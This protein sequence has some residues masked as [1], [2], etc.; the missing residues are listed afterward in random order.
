MANYINKK[1]IRGLLPPRPE[2]SN[3][4]T[5]G[6]VL[7]IA[8]S[9]NYIGAAHLSSLSALKMG[10][11]Y[12]SLACPKSIIPIIASTLHE[13]TFIPM[14]ETEDGTISVENK[15]SNLYEYNV[16][17]IG[18]GITTNDETRR[19]SF[20][21]INELNTTQKVIIDADGINMLANHK[22]EISL[23]NAIITPHPKELSRLLNVPVEEILNNREKYARITSQTYE[24]ITVL[25][26][27][28]SI[29]TNGETILIN[30]TGSSA[31]AKAGTG[32]VLTGLIA[33]LLAQRMKPFEAAILGTYIH[34]LAGD[35]AAKDLTK[36]SVIAS[37][38]I[39][40]FPL[41]INSILLDE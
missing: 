9:K 22:G 27:H 15:I 16:I 37:D 1:I 11:G 34:G 39:E 4:G 10:A 35:F 33:G 3:K 23:K 26:G 25:K 38:V 28:H 30:M 18:C 7:N 20:N 32:D 2:N 6:K 14:N 40:Y 21:L 13:V 31:L 19:F 41:A 17:S 12:V 29:V 8:G 36:Y 5:F 24:C